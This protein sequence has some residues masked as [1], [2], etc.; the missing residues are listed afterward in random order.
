MISEKITLPT[1]FS[2]ALCSL[3]FFAVSPL[4]KVSLSVNI[5]YLIFWLVRRENKIKST[6]HFVRHHAPAIH[7]IL[8]PITKQFD[9][10]LESGWLWW[11]CLCLKRLFLLHN[12]LPWKLLDK[13]LVV[14]LS[15]SVQFTPVK[16]CRLL[17]FVSLW[18]DLTSLYFQCSLLRKALLMLN[19]VEDL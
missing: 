8:Q 17:E 12:S 10:S 11:L 4:F 18:F 19:S 6:C 2:L 15:S 9:I 5:H 3:F 16:W 1:V 13:W 7:A 14:S